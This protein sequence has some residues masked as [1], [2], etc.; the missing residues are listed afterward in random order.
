MSAAAG[1]L[2]IRLEKIGSYSLG[3]GK[4]PSYKDI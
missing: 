2:G 3:E 1:S 4:L